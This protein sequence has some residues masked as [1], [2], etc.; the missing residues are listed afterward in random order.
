[1]K[2]IPSKSSSRDESRASNSSSASDASETGASDA[3]SSGSANSAAGRVGAAG[4][5]ERPLGRDGTGDGSECGAQGPFFTARYNRLTSENQNEEMT[6]M[7]NSEPRKFHNL[8]STKSPN[9][10]LDSTKSPNTG[11]D[12]AKSPNNCLE[13]SKVNKSEAPKSACQKQTNTGGPEGHALD[14]PST[15]GV[16]EYECQIF[17]ANHSLR[18]L[19]QVLQ[20]HW[21]RC[22]TARYRSRKRRHARTASAPKKDSAVQKGVQLNTK[23]I[24]TLK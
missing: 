9:I 5:G 16:T 18:G 4:G 1:M 2:R 8:D 14:V 10:G 24:T 15:A 12:S 19:A 3:L 21:S 20:E 11:L 23:A 13:S 22:M 17:V 6:E 7:H